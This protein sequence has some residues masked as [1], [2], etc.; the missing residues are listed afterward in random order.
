MDINEIILSDAALDV[1]D[2]GG[3]VGEDVHGLAGVRLKVC[4]VNA[5]EVVKLKQKK[6][7][8]LRKKNGGKELTAE[9]IE[10]LSSELLAEVILKDWEGLTS[11]GESMQIDRP[12]LVKEFK[13]R[14]GK[15]LALAITVSAYALD[16]DANRFVE[17]VTKNS[18]PA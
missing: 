16:Q 13:E 1:N 4:S 14:R 10:D 6:Q 18:S 8:A 12:Y 15:K 5:P 7:E 9:Q 3:W 11:N 17:E 2:N